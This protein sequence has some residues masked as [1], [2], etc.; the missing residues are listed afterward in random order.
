MLRID[1]CLCPGRR[2]ATVV[3]ALALVACAQQP[4]RARPAVVSLGSA[5]NAIDT[6]NLV[7]ARTRGDTEYDTA[8]GV[9]DDQRLM[10]GTCPGNCR[11]GPRAKIQPH[12]AASYLTEAERDTGAVIARIINLDSLAYAKFN[13]HPS[14]TVYWWVGRRHGEPVSVFIS[15]APGARPWVSNL[16]IEAHPDSP[17]RQPIAR[18][19]WD[20]KDEIAWGTCYG[21]RCC[22]SSG[23]P[24]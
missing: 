8:Y 9:G 21:G 2:A 16:E 13:L 18:W 3:A 6:V 22:R 5:K 20:D 7:L 24:L 10:V 19:L 1:R 14:D 11:Y 17:Y 23:T 4:Q 12:R 15:S